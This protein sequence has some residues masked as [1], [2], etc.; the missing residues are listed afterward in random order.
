MRKSEKIITLGIMASVILSLAIL[1]NM[2]SNHLDQFTREITSPYQANSLSEYE[3]EPLAFWS[4]EIAHVEA[5][6]LNTEILS[7]RTFEYNGK[8][9]T[10]EE[11]AYSSPNWVN[12]SKSIIRIRATI[13]YP[14]NYQTQVGTIPGILVMHGLYNDRNETETIGKQLVDLNCVILRPDHP[15][16]GQ[17]EGASPTPSNLYYQGNYNESAHNYLSICAAVQGIRVL[18]SLPSVNTTKLAVTGISYGG[19][20]SMY[21]GGVY[22]DKI[23]VVIPLIS[24][25]MLNES[26]AENMIF[27]TMGVHKTAI[28][29][30]YYTT[31]FRYFDPIAYMEK[32]TYPA[33]H[34]YMGTNDDFFGYPSMNAT[35]TR[36]TPDAGKSLQIYPNGHHVVADVSGTLRYLIKHYFFQGPRIPVISN[37][38]PQIQSTWNGQELQLQ[39]SVHNETNIKSVEVVYRYKS[40]PFSAWQRQSTVFLKNENGQ[41]HWQGTVAASWM[42]S[43]C[44]YYII[45]NLE[46]SESV[47]FSTPIQNAGYLSNYFAFLWILLI[48][49]MIM[50]PSVF[51]SKR[52]IHSLIKKGEK[53]HV[54]TPDQVARKQ[55]KIQMG[56]LVITEVVMMASFFLPWVASK[57]GNRW[58][59]TF[60]FN[61]FLT[62]SDLLGIISFNLLIITISSVGF[63]F[64]VSVW[65]PLWGGI[66]NCLFWTFCTV[67]LSYIAQ[68]VMGDRFGYGLYLYLSGALIQVIFAIVQIRWWKRIARIPKTES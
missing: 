56:M 17:S 51:F 54:P 23:R 11:I 61:H 62:Y 39:L 19:L 66:M 57:Y 13:Y 24:T 41:S 1:S 64:V 43:D 40:I 10:Q 52:N 22:S 67:L 46:G 53:Y 27:Q 14:P 26:Y 58:S 34:W 3:S 6:V 9:M 48:I 16:H 45:V 18:Q 47:W 28:S 21:L 33:I 15:G 31:K 49:G 68:G 5:T 8:L 50:V 38:Q 35:Y 60:L 36:I 55:F 32:S 59:M 12:E 30:T 29:Q 2:N 44:E 65:K 42:S 20:N 4:M 7:T 25:G 63:I 37:V